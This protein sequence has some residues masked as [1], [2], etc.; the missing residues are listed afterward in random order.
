MI[1]HPLVKLLLTL[2]A[3][4]IALL[5]LYGLYGD[6]SAKPVLLIS[7]AFHAIFPVA[8]WFTLTLAQG[9]L[10]Q[11][12]AITLLCVAGATGVGS[13]FAYLAGGRPAGFI[14]GH[15]PTMLGVAIAGLT[16]TLAAAD[17]LLRAPKQTLPR[18]AVG[19][20]LSLPLLALL[21]LLW[22]GS[23]SRALAGV[24]DALVFGAYI[25]LLLV[26]IALAS[27]AGHQI[28]R[29]FQIGVAAFKGDP[30]PPPA[31]PQSQ[32]S[33]SPPANQQAMIAPAPAT[34]P[35]AGV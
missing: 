35:A 5:G 16:A 14:T 15:W 3:G 32:A 17:V 10:R 31:P 26:L 4:V 29:A 23:I 2:T 34:T 25:I 30:A 18:L 24:S 33:V 8:A 19:L 7:A 27:A 22:R 6:L 12:P 9:R 20:A 28:I 21:A 13:V 11:G 1:Q